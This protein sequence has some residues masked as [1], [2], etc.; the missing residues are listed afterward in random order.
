M[1]RLK[2]AFTIVKRD[3]SRRPGMSGKTS[4]SLTWN[5]FSVWESAPS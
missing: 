4:S 5:L 3:P 1:L 2:D